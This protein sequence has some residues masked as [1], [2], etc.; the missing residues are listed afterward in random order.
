[1]L[2]NYIEGFKNRI[3]NIEGIGNVI[4]SECELGVWHD[5]ARD[6]VLTKGNV[7]LLIVKN[8][9][10][11]IESDPTKICP[12]DNSA[13]AEISDCD[14]VIGDYVCVYDGKIEKI[15]PPDF[16]IYNIYVSGKWTTD[17]SLEDQLTY[18]KNRMSQVYKQIK[19][20]KEEAEFLGFG[21]VD[22]KLYEELE[23]L[24]QKHMEISQELAILENEKYK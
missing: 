12:E 15:S 22:P 18:F 9:I 2:V 4:F 6:Y 7:F 19:E 5:I 11:L 1:M 20:Q 10:I 16:P 8:N 21:E 13:I 24:K 3:E 17:L 14:F 23:K